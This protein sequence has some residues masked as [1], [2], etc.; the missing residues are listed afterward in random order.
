[1]FYFSGSQIIFAMSKREVIRIQVSNLKILQTE[2]AS[3]T[4]VLFCEEPKS[5]LLVQRFA[6]VEPLHSTNTQFC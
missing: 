4:K 6:L 5:T 2:S 3:N 1:M